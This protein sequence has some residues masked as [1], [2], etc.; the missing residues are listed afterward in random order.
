MIRRPS[1]RGQALPAHDDVHAHIQ[2]ALQFCHD[3]VDL[4][5]E[6]NIPKKDA[7]LKNRP[8]KA[9]GEVAKRAEFKTKGGTLGRARIF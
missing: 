2:N 7:I 3:P 9:Q 5:A 1:P 8:D 4:P 6:F